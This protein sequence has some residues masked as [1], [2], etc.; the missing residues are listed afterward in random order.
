LKIDPHSEE[1]LELQK[2]M[3]CA[4]RAVLS[5]LARDNRFN[6]FGSV[7]HKLTGGR[8][9]AAPAGITFSTS[10]IFGTAARKSRRASSASR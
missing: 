4:A 8:A 9:A 5:F 7:R 6:R 2:E 10:R 1:L 3:G